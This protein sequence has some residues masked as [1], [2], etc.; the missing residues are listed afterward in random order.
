MLRCLQITNSKEKIKTIT[1]LRVPFPPRFLTFSKSPFFII[2]DNDRSEGARARFSEEAVIFTPIYQKPK[3]NLIHLIPIIQ[4]PRRSDSSS[5][6]FFY[7]ASMKARRLWTT[8]QKV[9]KKNWAREIHEDHSA[10][11]FQL[12]GGSRSRLRRF[13]FPAWKSIWTSGVSKDFRFSEIT[14]I[15]VEIFYSSLNSWRYEIWNLL[16][17]GK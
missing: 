15:K 6:T 3:S 9:K 7:R 13:E 16:V 5:F 8:F 10:Y 1:N 2:V 17:Y 4:N 14:E 12:S 11:H